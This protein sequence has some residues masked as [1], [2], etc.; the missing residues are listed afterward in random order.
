MTGRS[1]LRPGAR[2]RPNPSRNPARRSQQHVVRGSGDFLKDMGYVDPEEMRVKF[3]IANAIALAIEDRA[4][5]QGE[6]ARFTGLVRSD[7]ARIVNGAVKD[8]PFFRLIQ[9]LAALGKDI[10]IDIRRSASEQ[11]AIFARSS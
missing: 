2:P 10:L 5:T 6:A 9:A 4:L 3:V 11:G 7:V 1:K 8:Y